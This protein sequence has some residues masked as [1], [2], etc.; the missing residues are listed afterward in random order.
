MNT[1]TKKTNGSTPSAAFSGIVDKLFQ[2]NVGRFPDDD[3]WGFSG[4]ERDVN[5]PVNIKETDK[6]YELDLVAP[7]LRKED[8]KTTLNGEM[9]TVSFEQQEENSQQNKNESWVRKEFK[10]RSFSRSFSLD[11]TLDSG[12]ITASYN[13]GILHV[14]LPK[15]EGAQS[16]S[17]TIEIK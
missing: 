14:T 17:R 15:K 2:N 4:V 12:K 10:M 8:F 5:V 16:I 13:D 1:L 6:S 11:D 3:F 9:L 7:G